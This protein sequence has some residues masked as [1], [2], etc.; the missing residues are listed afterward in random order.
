VSG[1]DVEKHKPDPEPVLKALEVM[2]VRAD[3]AAMVGDSPFDIMCGNGAQV[4]T[5]AVGWT[6]FPRTELAAVGPT[7]FAETPADL[8]RI[9][10]KPN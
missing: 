9:F 2:G 7:A 3:T 8:L 4:K 1:N 10:A 5:L 6:T